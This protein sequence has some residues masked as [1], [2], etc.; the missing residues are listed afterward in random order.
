MK[1]NA[2]E[3]QGFF[4]RHYRQHGL[5]RLCYERQRRQR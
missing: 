2:T 1:T 4:A 3:M 5:A